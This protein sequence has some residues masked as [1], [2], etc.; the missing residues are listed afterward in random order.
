MQPPSAKSALRELNKLADPTRATL[1]R[2]FFKTGPGEYGE[3]DRFLGIQVP[4]IRHLVRGYRDLAEAEVDDL[5]AQPWHESRLLALLILV[6]QFKRGDDTRR[7]S[8]YDYYLAHTDR[9]NNWDLVDQS[10][11]PI[12]GGW[13]LERSRAPLRR[14]TRSKSLWERRIAII[15]TFHFIRN[16]Q[17]DDT[18]DIAER[19]LG[20][21][22]D[23]I[24]KAMGWMLR[25]VGKRDQ[26]RLEEFLTDNYARLPRTALRYAIERF[27]ETLRKRYL[28]GDSLNS[29]S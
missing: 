16:E 1:L 18:F 26:K 24:H 14:L 20:D 2:R 3:G 17:L 21:K 10:A 19:L 6:E 25:E 27:P 22:E 28:R 29:R 15:A 7:R 23:L 5:L 8:I 13:L 9:I 12:V 4:V 11:A